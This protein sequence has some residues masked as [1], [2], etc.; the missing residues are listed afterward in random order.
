MHEE[1]FYFKFIKPSPIRNVFNRISK[2]KSIINLTLG[3]PYFNTP[4]H[5]VDASIEALRRGETNYTTSY[6]IL[7]LRKAIAARYKKLY[8]ANFDPEE[9]CAS[10][11]SSSGIFTVL[12][13]MLKPEDEVVIID[14]YYV[15]YPSY[16][17]IFRAKPVFIKGKFEKQIQTRR[18]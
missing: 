8:R 12:L 2:D 14:P 17:R 3:E 4:K 13:S 18:I 6:G 10:Q 11:G 7:E 16:V 9:I 1:S 15:M 5:I